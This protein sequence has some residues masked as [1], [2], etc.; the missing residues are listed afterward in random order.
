MIKHLIYGICFLLLVACQNITINQDFKA[1]AQDSRVHYIII[2]YTAADF[3]RSL[4]LLTTEQ[5]SSHY[6]IDSA[7]GNIYQLVDEK[8]RAWHAGI[9]EW[10]GRTFINSSS[11]GIELVNLGYVD[12]PSGRTWF[13]Y[14]ENQINALV[15][16]LKDIQ[17]RHNISPEHIIGHSDVAPQRKTDPGPLFPW[18]RLAKEGIIVWPDEQIVTDKE[19]IYQAQ[20]LP[21][22][23]WFQKNLA[24][25]GYTIPQTGKLDKETQNVISAFQMRYQQ[26]NFTGT[27]NAKTAALINTLVNKQFKIPK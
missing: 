21:P 9:S 13:P 3:K 11:I 23:H 14:S 19:R 12:S 24:K 7:Q 4:S 10:Q 8:N 22:I 1:K 27:P 20:G 5:V 16:L 2:H 15:L 25:I 18:R 17:Q 26:E 6:L